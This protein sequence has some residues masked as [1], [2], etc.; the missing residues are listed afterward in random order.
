MTGERGRTCKK[1]IGAIK[2]QK[3][4]PREWMYCSSTG[5]CCAH[6]V[7]S[8]CRGKRGGKCQRPALRRNTKYA[9]ILN[10][11]GNQEILAQRSTAVRRCALHQILQ[12]LIV[13][14]Y[15]QRLPR[16]KRERRLEPQS[17]RLLSLSVEISWHACRLLFRQ[18]EVASF[19]LLVRGKEAKRRNAISKRNPKQ[20][21]AT[22]ITIIDYG[23]DA[24]TFTTASCPPLTLLVRAE[25]AS[26]KD[27]LRARP[28]PQRPG[29]GCLSRNL[30]SPI[31][32][33]RQRKR[34][35]SQ[36]S[37]ARLSL[38]YGGPGPLNKP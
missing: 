20:T 30:I 17:R 34:G 3:D 33:K 23:D 24:Q 15:I 18:T 5:L 8:V 16:I 31:T 14:T 25:M 27:S 38:T 9:W 7:A 1:K 28:V 35:G 2:I 12:P 11:H 32:N 21:T 36:G 10:F 22:M 13:V 26:T 6:G 19:F 4:Y 37:W 29:G